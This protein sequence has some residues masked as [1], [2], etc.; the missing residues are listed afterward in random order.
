[1]EIVDLT[2]NLSGSHISK[3]QTNDVEINSLVVIFKS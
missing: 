3:W 1:M 2:F